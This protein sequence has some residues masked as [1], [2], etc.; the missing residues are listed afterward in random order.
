MSLLG[1]WGQATHKSC[2]KPQAVD[3]ISWTMIKG[4][5]SSKEKTISSSFS[6]QIYWGLQE[7]ILSNF[8]F[9]IFFYLEKP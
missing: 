1:T 4:Y 6:I 8:Q 7:R 5:I 9:I 2:V 3:Y